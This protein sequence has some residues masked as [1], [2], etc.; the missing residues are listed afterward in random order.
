MKFAV[1]IFLITTVTGLA[2]AFHFAEHHGLD[3]E[4]FRSIVDAGPMASDVSRIKVEKMLREDFSVQAAIFDVL[5]NTRLIAAQA[6]ARD[7]PSPLLDRCHALF[8]ETFELG[9]RGS[10]MAAVLLALRARSVLRRKRPP[11]K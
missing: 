4:Q 8:E 1:N 11:K 9:Q 10:D 2:E 7:V 3:T 6:H 5:K